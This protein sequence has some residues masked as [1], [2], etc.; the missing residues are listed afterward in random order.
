MAQ[1][2]RSRRS[3]CHHSAFTLDLGRVL[4]GIQ[5]PPQDYDQFQQFLDKLGYHYVEETNNEVYKRY[6]RG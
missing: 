6:L 5:V 3:Q 1:V 2:S 4:T